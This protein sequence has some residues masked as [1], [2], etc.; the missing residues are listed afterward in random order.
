MGRARDGRDEGIEHRV[1]GPPGCGKTTYLGNQVQKAIDA[2]KKP[3]V[4]SLTRTA[5]AEVSGRALPLDS[6]AVGTLHSMCYRALGRPEI[7]EGRKYLEDWNERHPQ[8]ELTIATGNREKDIEE[9][10]P[11]PP[12]ELSRGDPLMNEYQAHRAKMKGDM[13]EHLQMFAQE[14]NA[15][16]DQNGLMDFTQLIEA[17][18]LEVDRAVD[19]PDVI[20]VDEAQDMSPLEMALLRKWGGAAGHLVIVGDPDQAIYTWRGAEPES[21]TQ[22]PL[23]DGR[24]LLL[25]Q[26]YRLPREVHKQATHWIDQS[27]DREKVQYRS[28]DEEGE[29]R[30]SA[31]TYRYPEGAIRD[32]EQYLEN[33]KTIMF[34]TSCSYMLQPM[35][36]FL[37]ANGIP[38][39]N[40]HRRSNGAWN[41]LLRRRNQ[42]G[43][44]DRLLAFLHMSERGTWSAEDLRRWTDA[45]RVKSAMVKGGKKLV[46]EIENNEQG[47]VSWKDIYNLLTEDAI[48][49]GLTGN[50]DWYRNQLTASRLK[51]SEFPINIA[52]REGS[53]GKLRETPQVITGTIHSAKGAEADVVYLFPD[54]SH[55]GNQEWKG[56]KRQQASIYRTFYVGMT[57]AKESLILCNP[58]NGY[59]AVNFP[60]LGNVENAQGRAGNRE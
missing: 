37:R 51:A 19:E 53:G 11:D 34:L 16:K 54:L 48:E 13:P 36:D 46:Q 49:A 59:A 38:F 10:Q 30:R 20:F 18:L 23:P 25:A 21:F 29:V 4:L 17:C 14:W 57:R 1:I 52:R 32:A 3:G 56:D 50:L 45:V 60:H 39:H 22:P 43:A 28:K 40:P 35:L 58:A 26:S 44:A 42:T 55:P 15:W 6:E 9:D 33:G 41:P 7:A 24:T 5:A 8:F 47:D 31:A 27:P 12:A 2:G